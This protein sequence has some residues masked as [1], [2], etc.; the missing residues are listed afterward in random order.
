MITFLGKHKKRFIF[1][2]ENDRLLEY[3]YN[4]MAEILAHPPDVDL[5]LPEPDYRSTPRI[6][7]TEMWAD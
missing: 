6:K 4:P 1:D 2:W 7:P 3:L 5:V